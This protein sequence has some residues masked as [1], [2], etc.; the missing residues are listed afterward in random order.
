MFSCN[1]SRLVSIQL[2]THSLFLCDILICDIF[3][4]I[5]IVTQSANQHRFCE[6]DRKDDQN[7]FPNHSQ[8]PNIHITINLTK[9]I[10]I[11]RIY[12]NIMMRTIERKNIVTN[13]LV[14][15]KRRR[16]EQLIRY[17]KY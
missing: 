15:T 7:V 1:R 17:V 14:N 16:T 6:E 3:C 5:K 13:E 8:C 2:E 4:R 12:A 9:Y 10:R 11:N